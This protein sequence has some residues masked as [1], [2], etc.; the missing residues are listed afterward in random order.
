M[1]DLCDLPTQ[2]GNPDTDE[3]GCTDGEEI[4]GGSDPCD[5]CDVLPSCAAGD[6]DGDGCTYS[7]EINGGSDPCDPCDYLPSCVNLEGSDCDSNG[8]IDECEILAGSS[9]D[10]NGNGVP[11]E[12]DQGACCGTDTR[13]KSVFA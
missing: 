10:C 4:V 13:A 12:C 3:D 9:V 1:T 11:D 8:E 5:P 2:P 6:V 7:E